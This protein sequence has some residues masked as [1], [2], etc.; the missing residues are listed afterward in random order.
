MRSRRTPLLAGLAAAALAVTGTVVTAPG[1]SGVSLLAAE[2]STYSVTYVA[3]VCD[4]YSDIMAN[5]ARNDI[6]ESLR[7][8]GVD[9]TYTAGSPVRPAVEDA[10]DTQIDN[11]RPL[12]DWRL[13]LGTGITGKTPG[14]LYLSTVTGAYG[15]SIVTQDSVPELNAAGLPTGRTVDG[16]VTVALTSAQADRAQRASALW[17]QGGTPSAPLNGLQQEYGFGALRCGIDNLNGDNVEWI[18]FSGQARHTFCYYYSVQ[19]P[20]ESAVINV[21]K[22]LATGTSGPASFTYTGNISY[23]AGD[24]FTLTPQSS[25]QPASIQFIRAAGTTWDFEEEPSDGFV[26]TGP[27]TCTDTGGDGSSDITITGQRVEVDPAPGATVT[28]TYINEA[29]VTGPLTLR[30]VT[31]GD[32]GTFD[33][34]VDFPTG[35]INEYDVTTVEQGVP[36]LVTEQQAGP[37]GAYQVTET[38]PAGSARGTW[39]LTSASCNGNELTVASNSF[40]GVV[41]LGESVDCVVENTFTPGGSLT[42]RKTAIGGTAT[43]G[44]SVQQFDSESGDF[45]GDAA[46]AAADVTVEET[47]TTAVVDQ[48]QSTLDLGALP[49]G[50]SN[51]FFVLN[52]LLPPS[53]ETGT[54]RTESVECTGNV[55]TDRD[56][57]AGVA[58]IA[59][60]EQAPNVVCDFV[61]VFVPSSRLVVTKVAE[62]P[63]GSRSAPVVVDLTCENGTEETLSLPVSEDERSLPERFFFE[64]DICTVSE[65]AT[66]V[67]PGFTVETEILAVAD[68]EVVDAITGSEVEFELLPGDDLEI[69]VINTY[70]AEDEGGGGGGEGEGEGGEEGEGGVAGGKLPNT[71]S[72][73]TLELASWAAL[74]VLVGGYVVLM[75]RAARRWTWS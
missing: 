62:G 14:S 7:D 74:L 21:R 36:E 35:T 67:A 38:L 45:T 42:I 41:G 13:T 43:F 48:S 5:R 15:T 30:K 57:L 27:P 65:S 39:E 2:A 50:E 9:T 34:E 25:T 60:T 64:E 47:P 18:G 31:Q 28:C 71:G 10:V 53:D 51:S 20:P 16:A 44:Y 70:V 24:E 58:L 23:N 73:G 32:V 61:N 3:R 11:C 72:D 22:Q 37:T 54:W 63:E 12:E 75:S 56:V 46:F 26:P 1:A 19:P 55:L 59:I 49:V 66:G 4:D 68:G 17:V 40:G 6:Q 29:D 52:E 69:V 33:F 8:L